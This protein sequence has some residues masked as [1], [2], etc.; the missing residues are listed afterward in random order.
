MRQWTQKVKAT[1]SEQLNAKLESQ[2]REEIS[3]KD[4]Q[5]RQFTDVFNDEQQII[6][7]QRF[8]MLFEPVLTRKVN[9]VVSKARFLIRLD[10]PQSFLKKQDEIEVSDLDKGNQRKQDSL[11][12]NNNSVNAQKS[13]RMSLQKILSQSRVQKSM[14]LQKEAAQTSLDST[15]KLLPNNNL[16]ESMA[17]V[18]EYVKDERNEDQQVDWR[19]RLKQ[20][21]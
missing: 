18:K 1:I 2:L 6:L 8:D 13:Q 10:V 14:S 16:L 3:K 11:K 5:R 15:M 17:L 19:D 20:W 4:P 21:K 12:R 7:Q 9:D